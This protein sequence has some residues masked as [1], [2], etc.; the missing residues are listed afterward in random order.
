MKVEDGVLENVRHICAGDKDYVPRYRATL[1]PQF[2][3]HSD[4][5]PNLWNRL[6][7]FLLLGVSF[8]KNANPSADSTT[9]GEKATCC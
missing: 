4:K 9:Q 7:W 3:Y 8:K 2:N 6:W 5:I 1:V